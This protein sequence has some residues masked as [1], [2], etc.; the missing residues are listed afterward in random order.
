SSMTPRRSRRDD[1]SS[2]AT[3]CH[4]AAPRERATLMA[5]ASPLPASRSAAMR[6]LLFARPALLLAALVAFPAAPAHSAEP[7]RE[8]VVQLSDR[9]AG[10]T[11]LRA[12]SPGA[13]PAAV[14]SRFAALGVRPT[15]AFA[16]GLQARDA[17]LPEIY[18]FHPERIVLVEA[19]EP[20]LAASALAA[21]ESD[22]LVDWAER[23]VTRAVALVGYGPVPAA[24]PAARSLAATALDSLANDP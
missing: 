8:L 11:A 15:R 14:R 21:L 4:G 5:P 13:L 12:V 9:A 3:S 19:P 22:P 20:A 1:V 7:S 18:A 2:P 17:P 10:A 16:E 6:A 24:A 23:N